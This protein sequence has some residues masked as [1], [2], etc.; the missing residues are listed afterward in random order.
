MSNVFFM[1]DN[2]FSVLSRGISTDYLKV[3]T[4]KYGITK[5]KTVDDIVNSHVPQSPNYISYINSIKQ[6]LVEEIQKGVNAENSFLEIGEKLR[7]N[8]E[9][10]YQKSK[11]ECSQKGKILV[12]DKK[13][14]ELLTIPQHIETFRK[15]CE[16]NFFRELLEKS[17]TGTP[18]EI[19]EFISNNTE[20]IA[21]GAVRF[22]RD[23]IWYNSKSCEIFID[24][25]Y[26]IPKISGYWGAEHFLHY[27]NMMACGIKLSVLESILGGAANER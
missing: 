14:Y 18:Q 2:T 22:I 10:T 20:K 5:V 12:I 24:G 11:K 16:P 23:K 13:S 15:S 21:T 1:I 19:S 25:K 3:Y 6:Q 27:K 26:Y 17:K 8:I 7:E 9:K 4:Q